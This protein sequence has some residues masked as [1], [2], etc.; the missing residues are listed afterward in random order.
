MS[1]LYIRALS[2]SGIKHSSDRCFAVRIAHQLLQ[3]EINP[4]GHSEM[5]NYQPFYLNN[6]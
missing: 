6:N 4:V 1:F 5:A 3:Q 2:R